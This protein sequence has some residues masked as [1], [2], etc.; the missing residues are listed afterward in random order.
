MTANDVT[1]FAPGRVNLIGDHTDYAGGLALPCAI[2]LGLTISGH[3]T[4]DRIELRSESMEG[5]TSFDL[6]TRTDISSLEPRWGRYVAAVV[7]ELGSTSGFIGDVGST[8][9]AGAGLSSSAAFEIAIA[10]ALGFSGS[11]MQL[12]LLG[13]RAELRAVGVPCGLLD[14]LSIVFG[15][16]EY[17]MVVDF[18]DNAIEHVPFPEGLDI[19]IV[20]SGQERQLVDSA[21]AERRASCELA[22]SR[23]G[24]LST[25]SADDLSTLDG[26]LLRRAR[27]VS[28]E[29]ER[30]RQ[31]AL[32]LRSGDPARVGRLMVESHASLRDDFDVSTSVLDQL[33]E[34]LTTI[35]GVFGARLT[36]AGFGGCVVAL[37]ER[38]A[39]DDPT[40]ISG[41]GWI[42]RPSDGARTLTA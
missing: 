9:P 11:P 22:T 5:V 34:R 2:D 29:C 8:L 19:W 30:V 28:T 24:P 38:G 39:V 37:C 10:L 33:V 6:G 18:T 17:A 35:P 31:A 13:Q 23:I 3:R 21:Y 14:Q 36:G 12:A 7:E 1:V 26:E 40:A 4:D 16:A 25:A 42:V 32:A 20:H 15:R 27:H 41:R